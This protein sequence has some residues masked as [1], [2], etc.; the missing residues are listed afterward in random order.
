MKLPVTE[1]LLLESVESEWRPLA[2][3]FVNELRT[4]ALIELNTGQKIRIKLVI[5]AIIPPE[6]TKITNDS[7]TTTNFEIISNGLTRVNHFFDNCVR[8]T[9]WTFFGYI[10][11]ENKAPIIII[12]FKE[13]NLFI[14]TQ[15][16]VNED[17]K[18]FLAIAK[19][20]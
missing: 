14:Y 5:N 12:Y 15:K 13:V 8:K 6:F 1:R 2:N 17:E 19:Q 18:D 16:L 3:R 11:G 4:S 9:V 10:D 20:N 7:R